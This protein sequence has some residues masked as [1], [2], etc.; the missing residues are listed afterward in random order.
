MTYF[1]TYFSFD[2]I[3]KNNRL[4]FDFCRHFMVIVF[5]PITSWP[6]QVNEGR[7]FCDACPSDHILLRLLQMTNGVMSLLDANLHY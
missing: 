2:A 5:E 3:N 7:T 6:V 1:S 4:P